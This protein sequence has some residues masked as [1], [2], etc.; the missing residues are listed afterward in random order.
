MAGAIAPHAA[1][2]ASTLWR[3]ACFRFSRADVLLS[4]IV[5]CSSRAEFVPSAAGRRRRRHRC[6]QTTTRRAEGWLIS[7]A[8]SRLAA[9]EAP[10]C[11]RTTLTRICG[12]RILRGSCFRFQVCVCSVGG[13]QNEEVNWLLLLF[14]ASAEARARARFTWPQAAPV[15]NGRRSALARV[16]PPTTS[17]T[18]TKTSDFSAA[19]PTAA[20]ILSGRFVAGGRKQQETLASVSRLHTDGREHAANDIN[21]RVETQL[22]RMMF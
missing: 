1:T 22:A 12:L 14:C 6:R 18:S 17:T 20:E 7:A 8:A 3:G 19:R 21:S 2:H 9:S 4:F 15:E 11:V 16:C 13:E 5:S 10:S